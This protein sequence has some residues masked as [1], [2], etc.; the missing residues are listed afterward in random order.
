[1]AAIEELVGARARDEKGRFT[2]ATPAEPE[3]AEAAPPEPVQPEVKEP[4]APVE[5]PKAEVPPVAP[6]AAPASPTQLV[7]SPETA[8]YKRAMQEERAKRQALQAEIE[9][10]KKPQTP[11]V[12][13]WTDL[14]GALAQQ[15]KAFQEQLQQQR[16]MIS[17]DLAR[18][19]YKDF[20]E[21]L[22]HFNQAVEA[23]PA[24][25]NQMVASRNPAEFAY[26][27]GLLHKELSTVNGDPLAYRTKLEQDLRT[28]LEA[29]Y[30]AK[31][32]VKAAPAVPTSLNSDASPPQAEA[33]YQGPPPLKSILRNASRS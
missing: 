15:Q 24:L 12:D 23:N 11:P 30:A 22:G 9:A 25:A 29:E 2:T 28:K 27:Q 4:V 21:V 5:S 17:E 32:G 1:M 6:M 16:L 13:P 8:A 31:Y 3:K 19:K 10:L 33:V 26:K 7:E 18:E 20:E 14:P